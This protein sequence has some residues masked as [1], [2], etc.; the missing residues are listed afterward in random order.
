MNYLF[1]LRGQL[2]KQ[3]STI[4]GVIGS[5]LILIIWWAI[6]EFAGISSAL[7]PSPQKVLVSYSELH[8]EDALI[9]NIFYSIKLNLYGA[10]EA[11]IIS[12]VFGFVLG[13]FPIFREMFR[14]HLDT[15]RFI[16]LTAITGLF[17][18]YF[19]IED[20]M[21]IQFLSFGIIV[22]LLPIVIQRIS[23]LED[24]YV[25]TAKTLGASDFQLIFKVFWAGVIPKLFDDIRVIIPLSWTYIIVAELVNK[26][27]GIGSLAYTSARQSRTDKVFAIL[28]VIIAIGFI[29][30]RL[31][32]TLDK[33]LFK[34]KYV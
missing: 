22:Y 4:L 1:E 25:Q 27:G 29:Q 8:F 23:E 31:F 13:L 32:A 28:F 24:V 30:D 18:L 15:I 19:G 11:I 14:K 21:K 20:E 5:F 3:L 33:M 26:S 10:L 34:Y 2:T 7:L 12:I 17:I 6:T 16:P 9:L